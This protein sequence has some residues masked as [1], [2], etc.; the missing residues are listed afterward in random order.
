MWKGQG[1]RKA[2]HANIIV[3]VCWWLKPSRWL[4]GLTL[5]WEEENWMSWLGIQRTVGKISQIWRRILSKLEN[6]VDQGTRKEVFGSR[7][8]T[9]VQLVR[10]HHRISEFLKIVS[11]HESSLSRHASMLFYFYARFYLPIR[12][13]GMFY[14]DTLHRFTNLTLSRISFR[15]RVWEPINTCFYQ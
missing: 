11:K 9:R 4:W 8:Q 2:W 3:V 6:D 7:V 5:L 10:T 12:T 14:P 13:G 1:T 15:F